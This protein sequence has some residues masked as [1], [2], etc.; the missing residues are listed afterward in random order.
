MNPSEGILESKSW[1]EFEVRVTGLCVGFATADV[2]CY[3]GH[4]CVPLLLKVE[5]VIDGPS[6]TIGQF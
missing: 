1:E 6:V 2:L 5:A 4:S 3:V